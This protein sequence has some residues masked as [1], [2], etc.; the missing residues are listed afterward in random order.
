VILSGAVSREDLGSSRN[1]Y[2]ETHLLY[3]GVSSQ[4]IRKL[5]N[6]KIVVEKVS[7]SMAIKGGLVGPNW[8]VN[9]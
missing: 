2:V 8:E 7:S 1:Y 5:I 6:Q 4:L 3:E 9:F